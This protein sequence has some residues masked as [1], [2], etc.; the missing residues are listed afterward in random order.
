MT[1][2]FQ[3]QSYDGGKKLQASFLR[4]GN[5]GG[6]QQGRRVAGEQ[7]FPNSVDIEAMAFIIHRCELEN[8]NRKPPNEHQRANDR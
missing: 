2:N 5:R 7:Q 6:R 8:T 1:T 4:R 3:W